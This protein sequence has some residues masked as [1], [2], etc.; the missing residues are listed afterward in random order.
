[1]FVITLRFSDKTKAPLFMEGHNA[2]IKR[3]F[4][5]GIFL[6]AGRLQPDAGGAILA[7]HAS[8]AAIEARVKDDPFVAE[9]VVSAEILEIE[10]GRVE[11][12]LV[13][14]KA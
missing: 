3:G 10:P 7:H 1:M 13:F 9:G 11:E 8:R 2:W 5:D 14:L 4:D 12:R 6:L